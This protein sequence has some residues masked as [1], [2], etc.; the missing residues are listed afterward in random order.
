MDI[1]VKAFA[2]SSPSRSSADQWPH[3]IPFSRQHYPLL[4][5]CM[6]VGVSVPKAMSSV[7]THDI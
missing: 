5:V 1:A 2:I 6:I 3:N 4:S 7:Y